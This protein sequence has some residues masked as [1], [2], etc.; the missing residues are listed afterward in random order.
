MNFVKAD[1]YCKF[2]IQN[3]PLIKT[4]TEYTLGARI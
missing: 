4:C 3:I 2:R 1:W